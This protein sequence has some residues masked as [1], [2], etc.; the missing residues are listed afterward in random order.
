[1][2]KQLSCCVVREWTDR[3]SRALATTTDVPRGRST[4]EAKPAAAAHASMWPTFDLRD[5]HWTLRVPTPDAGVGPHKA[6]IAAPT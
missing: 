2:S 4:R 5:A 6:P 1:M 3:L